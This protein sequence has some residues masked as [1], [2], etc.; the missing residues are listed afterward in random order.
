MQDSDKEKDIQRTST[1][2]ICEDA[3]LMDAPYGRHEGGQGAPL[4]SSALF[5]SSVCL[6]ACLS[7]P[8]PLML[9]R[10]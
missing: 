2:N 7:I 5:V 10:C 4:T 9:K 8:I 6:S 1:N 3:F